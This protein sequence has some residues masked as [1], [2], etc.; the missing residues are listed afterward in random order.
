M[1]ARGKSPAA[2]ATT[3]GAVPPPP[4]QREH[5]GVRTAPRL[6]YVTAQG[7]LR[8]GRGLQ[9]SSAF[10]AHLAA[11]FGRSH[12]QQA[13]AAAAAA[14]VERGPP[15]RT[16]SWAA[17]SWRS[18]RAPPQAAARCPRRS[19]AGT[20]AALRVAADVARAPLAAQSLLHKD[21]R[22]ERAHQ[23]QTT[24][25]NARRPRRRRQQRRRQQWQWQLVACGAHLEP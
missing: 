22:R 14:A 7:H 21:Q 6:G 8:V 13:A 20:H 15:C 18:R 2:A 25:S 12:T 1:R 4:A 3:C 5:N 17:R 16:A 11:E 10:L 23:H 24:P 9:S 19:P